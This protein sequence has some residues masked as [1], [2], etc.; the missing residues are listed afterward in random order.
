MAELWYVFLERIHAIRCT[1]QDSQM[2]LSTVVPLCI[3][4]QSFHYTDRSLNVLTSSAVNLRCMSSEE[5][6]S[7]VI[8]ITGKIVKGNESGRDNLMR[9][10]LQTLSLVLLL[11]SRFKSSKYL[12]D[13]EMP[14]NVEWQHIKTSTKLVDFSGI[15]RMH[16]LMRFGQYSLDFYKSIPQ[17]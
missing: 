2:D 12:I 14:W 4:T 3:S 8:H 6:T 17:I 9:V 7:A 5:N 13:F 16:P 10:M 15:W 1:H 11:G